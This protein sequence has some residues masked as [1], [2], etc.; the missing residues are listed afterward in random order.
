[1]VKQSAASAL[2]FAFSSQWIATLQYI[3]AVCSAA[4]EAA[5]DAVDDDAY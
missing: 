2:V 1:M 3:A 4:A 5:G